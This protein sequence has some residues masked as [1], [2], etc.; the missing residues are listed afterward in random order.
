MYYWHIVITLTLLSLLLIGLR[1]FSFSFS[2]GFFGKGRAEK[3]PSREKVPAFELIDSQVL[4]KLAVDVSLECLPMLIDAFLE[5][6]TTRATSVQTALVENDSKALRIEVHSIKSCCRT[7][8][9]IGLGTKAA[10]IEQMIVDKPPHL[11]Q[12]INQMLKFI[13]DVEQAF[14]A[15]R[16]TLPE[17]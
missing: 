11:A 15:Y 10:E 16:A 5:E 2:G 8:G 17:A 7:F 4:V 1:Q 13:P 14:L 12:E 3:Q 9:A 6:L